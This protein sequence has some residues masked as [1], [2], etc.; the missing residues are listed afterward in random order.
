MP[1]KTRFRLVANLNRTGLITR[2]VPT[3]G[4]SNDLYIASPLSRL[5]W[6]TTLHTLIHTFRFDD[7]LPYVA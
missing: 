4:F 7:Q 3:Q 6:R 2:R 1:R 5:S